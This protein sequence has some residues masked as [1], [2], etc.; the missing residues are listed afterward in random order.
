MSL[1]KD[2]KHT[3]YFLYNLNYLYMYFLILVEC[4]DFIT[5]SVFA[6]DLTLP[7]VGKKGNRHIIFMD[8][9]HSNCDVTPTK[10]G[11]IIRY[12]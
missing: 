10:P 2:W 12:C 4:R 8:L 3:K 7:A 6:Y 11:L 1:T 9:A 5:N